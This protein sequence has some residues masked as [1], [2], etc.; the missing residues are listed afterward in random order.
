MQLYFVF[1][2]RTKDGNKRYLIKYFENKNGK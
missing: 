2:L 1:K